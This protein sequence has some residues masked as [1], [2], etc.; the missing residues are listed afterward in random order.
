M[1][2]DLRISVA[3]AIR[4]IVKAGEA[5][6]ASAFVEEAVKDRLRERRRK[7]VYAA[8]AEASQDPFLAAEMARIEQVFDA[9]IGDGVP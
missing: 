9:T 5:P 6:N 7:R 1:S 2:F 8:Y 3:E 4:A